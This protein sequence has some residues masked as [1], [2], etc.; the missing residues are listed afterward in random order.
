MAALPQLG[1]RAPDFTLPL[2]RDTKTILSEVL[3]DQKAVLLFYVLSF[4]S[5]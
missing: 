2:S 3:R 4:S 1:D 5:P